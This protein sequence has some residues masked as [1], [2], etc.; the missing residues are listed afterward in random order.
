MGRRRIGEKERMEEEEGIEMM[1]R[2][3]RFRRE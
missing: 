2:E 1:E 3:G